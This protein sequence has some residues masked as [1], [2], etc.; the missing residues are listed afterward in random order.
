M[1][2]RTK[3]NIT[4]SLATS[5]RLLQMSTLTG[6]TPEEFIEAALARSLDAFK[7][8]AA[9]ITKEPPAGP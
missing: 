5:A 6:E 2:H 3:P 7:E 8:D 9:S 4:L 1:A